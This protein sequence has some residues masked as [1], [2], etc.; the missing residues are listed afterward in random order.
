MALIYSM[1]KTGAGD[2]NDFFILESTMRQ[3]S[4][5]HVHVVRGVPLVSL[6]ILMQPRPKWPCPL[7]P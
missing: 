3:K 2:L 5:V 6:E 7:N 1:I 4:M